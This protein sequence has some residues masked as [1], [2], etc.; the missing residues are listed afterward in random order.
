MGS[1]ERILSDF[2]LFF[3]EDSLDRALFAGARALGFDCASVATENRWGLPDERQL[4]FAAS[5]DR[6]VFTNNVRDFAR[7][8]YKWLRAGREHGGIILLTEQLM[9]V[10]RQLKGL[11]KLGQTFTAEEMRNRLVFLT[12]Y[13]K[14]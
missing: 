4:E 13:C 3:D 8:Y 1:R 10:G 11:E 6:V 9:P 5:A 12:N 14:A 2:S 7:L